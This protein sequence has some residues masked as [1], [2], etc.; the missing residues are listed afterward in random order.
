MKKLRKISQK[1][2]TN[3]HKGMIV[4]AAL[5]FIIFMFLPIIF[6]VVLSLTNWNG[7]SS[8]QF[9]GFSNFIRILGDVRAKNAVE[10]SVVFA[11]LSVPLLN[12]LGLGYALLLDTKF[13][14][15]NIVKTIVYIPAVIS[16][17]IMGYLW[18]FV[19]QERHGVIKT[20]Y[21]MFG[22]ADQYVNLL[23]NYGLALFVIII[24]NAFQFVGLT[25][26]I[27]LAGLQNIPQDLYESSSID[28]AN[29]WQQFRDITIPMLGPSILINVVTNIIGSLA[30][31]DLVVSLTGGG[32]GYATETI[33][34]YIYRMSYSGF[35]GYAS[36]LSL[37]TFVIIL[38]PVLISL[39]L[40]KK[41]NLYLEG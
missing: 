23:G 30:I 3:L 22:H 40:M 13:K 36:S 39:K 1:L 18:M 31:F 41:S 15:A 27:Y 38:I 9:I 5:L 37:I 24:I 10:N 7:Y 11:L 29:K 19:L 20:I 6:S 17:L 14:G 26:T 12:L 34:L 33:S 16:P 21:E 32:P 28:G 35:K 25:M 8:P 2:N 4:P